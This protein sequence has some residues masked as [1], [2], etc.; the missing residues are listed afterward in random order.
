M[1][2]L[3]FQIQ[4]IY[5]GFQRDLLVNFQVNFRFRYI[6]EFSQTRISYGRESKPR[7]LRWKRQYL[8]VKPLVLFMMSKFY[9][10]L[11]HW[12]KN[13]I[14]LTQQIHASII[15]FPNI[16]SMT[17]ERE[18]IMDEQID[19]RDHWFKEKKKLIVSSDGIIPLFP[20]EK[21][22]IDSANNSKTAIP[23]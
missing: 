10:V 20:R 17:S 23:R 2:N 15:Y 11:I 12:L 3:S 5:Q 18:W 9:N 6:Q 21:F 4:L 14:S 22:A 13:G 16:R 8:F 1:P 7:Y 19:A